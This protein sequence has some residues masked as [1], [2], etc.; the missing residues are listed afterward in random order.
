MF[1]SYIDNA[2]VS[3]AIMATLTRGD[4]TKAIRM[5]L[6]RIIGLKIFKLQL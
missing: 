1:A 3:S 6:K 2:K 4:Y 5:T